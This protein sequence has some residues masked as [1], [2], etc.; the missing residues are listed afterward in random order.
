MMTLTKLEY[1][2]KKKKNENIVIRYAIYVTKMKDYAKILK[3]MS[4]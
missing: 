2:K 4:I 1:Y 3:K